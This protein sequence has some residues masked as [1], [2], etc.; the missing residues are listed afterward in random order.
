MVDF[1]N[2]ILSELGAGFDS[3]RGANRPYSVPARAGRT[4]VPARA[5]RT[6]IP[7]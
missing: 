6:L 5:G 4:L 2:H 1:V 3:I 7:G